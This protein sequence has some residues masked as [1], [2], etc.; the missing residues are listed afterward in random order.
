M[1]SQFLQWMLLRVAKKVSDKHSSV[2]C[3]QCRGVVQFVGRNHFLHSIEE[4]I[5]QSD[6]SL[7]RSNEDIALLDSYASIKSPLFSYHWMLLELQVML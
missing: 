7:R 5:L 6:S 3:P 2:L 1:P 4:D